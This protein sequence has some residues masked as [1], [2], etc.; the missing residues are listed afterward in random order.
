MLQ[1]NKLLEIENRLCYNI[2]TVSPYAVCQHYESLLAEAKSRK[3]GSATKA[4][5]K[6]IFSRTNDLQYKL[7]KYAEEKKAVADV[8]F[9]G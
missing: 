6:A 1:R 3:E 2:F 4:V 7:E 9:Y 5:E 8:S